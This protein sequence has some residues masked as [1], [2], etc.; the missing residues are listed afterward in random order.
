MCG[1]LIF[2][3]LGRADSCLLKAGLLFLVYLV[4]LMEVAAHYTDLMRGNNSAYL[5]SVHKSDSFFPKML[6][7]AIQD[8]QL[9]VL[10]YQKICQIWHL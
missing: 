6:T 10:F 9:G 8:Q 2:E 3:G 7:N 4:C 5:F 1:V